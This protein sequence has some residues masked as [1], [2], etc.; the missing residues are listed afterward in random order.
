MAGLPSLWT[1]DAVD[2]RA[3]LGPFSLSAMAS[4]DLTLNEAH[5]VPWLIIVRI[6]ANLTDPTA[7]HLYAQ[8]HEEGYA[9]WGNEEILMGFVKDAVLTPKNYVITV[10]VTNPQAIGYINSLPQEKD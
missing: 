3:A 7:K 4:H 2:A 1:P 8:F 6:T 9:P 10:D 5:A